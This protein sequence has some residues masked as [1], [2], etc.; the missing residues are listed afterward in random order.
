MASVCKD[1]AE[2]RKRRRHDPTIDNDTVDAFQDMFGSPEDI[3]RSHYKAWLTRQRQANHDALA[4]ELRAKQQQAPVGQCIADMRA[5]FN[6][7]NIRLPHAAESTAR[8]HN[9]QAAAC[10]I[11]VPP[12]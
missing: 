10:S 2:G 12:P 9:F 8:K 4:F 5:N 11:R 6:S 1:V 3:K 7:L